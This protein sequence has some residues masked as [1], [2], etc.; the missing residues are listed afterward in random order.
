MEKTTKKKTSP[1]MNSDDPRWNDQEY[2]DRL[3]LPENVVI[4]D[5]LEEGM[6]YNL[7][8]DINGKEVSFSYRYPN[9]FKTDYESAQYIFDLVNPPEKI[10]VPFGDVWVAISNILDTIEIPYDDT[11]N[12][13][14]NV[15]DPP[16]LQA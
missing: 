14:F 12:F 5:N 11:K 9:H 1:R 7:T 13:T 8:G 16:E 6:Y 4:D 10:E 3:E 2:L 15:F